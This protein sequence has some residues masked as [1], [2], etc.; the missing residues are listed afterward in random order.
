MESVGSRLIF[1]Y[2]EGC[3]CANDEAAQHSTVGFIKA[4]LLIK[5]KALRLGSLRQNRRGL[6]RE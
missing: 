3:K 6:E 4:P 5:N 1:T 2:V